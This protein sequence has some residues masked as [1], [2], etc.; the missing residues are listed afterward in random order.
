MKWMRIFLDLQRENLSVNRLSDLFGIRLFAAQRP[1]SR[2]MGVHLF[3][4]FC[5]GANDHVWRSNKT[6]YTRNNNFHRP[7]CAYTHSRAV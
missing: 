5:T 1:R 6:L 2:V 3:K 7:L 4:C